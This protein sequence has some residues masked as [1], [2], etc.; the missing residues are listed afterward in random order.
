MHRACIESLFSH[1]YSNMIK[2][3]VRLSFRKEE[4]DNFK[5]IFLNS[6]LKIKAR[7]GCHHLELWQ[8]TDAP[9][10]FFTYS[11]W[12]DQAAL[13]AYRH[14]ELFG[15]VWAKTKKLFDDKPQAWSVKV[16]DIVP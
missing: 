8:D 5:Q 15:T 3:I 10:V 14:S 4:I 7:E 12:D 11:Y 13:D 6:K 1:L 16:L 2:R 9:N